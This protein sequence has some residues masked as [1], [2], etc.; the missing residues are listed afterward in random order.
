MSDVTPRTYIFAIIIFTLLI[1]G[2]VSIIGA[3]H[4]SDPD[5]IDTDKYQQFNRSFNK[6]NDVS[7][8][9][10]GLEDNIID[11]A[12]D[13]G[14]FGVLNSLINTGWQTLVLLFNSFGFM[15]GVFE[16]MSEMFGVPPWIISLVLLLITVMLVFTIFSAI[17]QKDI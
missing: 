17:F 7:D 5:V 2:S 4:N 9:V 6:I 12:P 14:A 16:A 1:V 3:F 11:A 13:Q 10:T 8:S 15:D